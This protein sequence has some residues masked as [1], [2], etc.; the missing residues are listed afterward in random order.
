MIERTPFLNHEN[1]TVSSNM[2]TTTDSTSLR[3]LFTTWEGGGNVAPALTVARKLAAR[4]HRVRFMCDAA[5]KADAEAAGAV[6]RSWSLA[7]NREDRT[8]ESCPVKDW[9]AASPPEG[10]QRLMDNIM[11]GRALEYAQD[12]IAE[13]EREPADVVVTSEMLP[14]VLAACESLGQRVA[15]FAANLCLYPLPG[16][17]AFGPGLPPPR[18]REENALHDQIRAGTAA[19][20]DAGLDALNRARIELGLLPLASAVDQISVA[21]LYMLGTSRVFDFPVK[22]LPEQIRYV[23]PQMDEPAWA[24]PWVSPW[25]ASDRRPM[26]TV[27]FSTTFQ[28]HAGVL[29]NVIDAAATLPVKALVTLGQ[30]GN[31]EVRAA[32]NTALVPSAPHDQV[33]RESAV[34]VTHGG[35]GTVMRALL[36]RRP[37]L[38]IPH[39]RDQHENAVRVT[40]R[41]AGICLPANASQ[42]QIAQA[43][44]SLLED[45]A[46]AVAAAQL[47]AVIA[48]ERHHPSVTALLE[49]YAVRPRAKEIKLQAM[50]A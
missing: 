45:P 37:M 33:I 1:K 9:E 3:F 15:I 29:Q 24:Q 40:E 22:R 32:E 14:G 20:F 4:G 46:Y 38:I 21:D 49:Q 16:M 50:L 11:L 19:M 6:F 26:I 17:P 27:G 48:E 34:V 12:V 10:I 31:G 43:L 42:E 36:Q 13:L 8:R 30:I 44:R 18:T 7:P 35:H 2:S 25:A 41:G 39:G 23:G 5:S 28:N 47:G